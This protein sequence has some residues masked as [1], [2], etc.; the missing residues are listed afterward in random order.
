MHAINYGSVYVAA[1][2]L[3]ANDAQTVKAFLEAGIV[4]G[5]PCHC[6][7]PLHLAWN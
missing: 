4:D 6:L 7:L 3:G 2:A 1:V 5:P